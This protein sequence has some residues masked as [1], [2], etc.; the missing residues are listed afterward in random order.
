MSLSVTGNPFGSSKSIVEFIRFLSYYILLFEVVAMKLFEQLLPTFTIWYG[1][2]LL[3]IYTHYLYHFNHH[4]ALWIQDPTSTMMI[5]GKGIKDDD[6]FRR[7]ERNLKVSERVFVFHGTIEVLELVF[8]TATTTIY[9]II[10]ALIQILNL[11]N[12]YKMV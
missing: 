10:I 5:F 6:L 1:T 4:S 8:P 12:R 7:P 9:M 2:L 3:P 11:M